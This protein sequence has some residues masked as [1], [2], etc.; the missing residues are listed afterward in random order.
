MLFEV[1]AADPITFA[2]VIAVVTLAS[3]FASWAPLR[4]ALAVEPAAALRAE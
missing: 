4:R 2:T 1:Q 3:L